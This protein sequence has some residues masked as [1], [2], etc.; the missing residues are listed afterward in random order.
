MDYGRNSPCLCG[1][2]KKYKKCCLDRVSIPP[3][4]SCNKCG[5]Q[6]PK[7][8]FEPL[9]VSEMKGIELAFSGICNSCKS[10][11]IAVSGEPDAASALMAM[12][13]D[14]VGQGE[15]G[16]ESFN[17]EGSNLHTALDGLIDSKN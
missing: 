6:A 7:S 17:S 5:G 10:M 4:I 11:T 16:V 13:Q 2:G 12:L 3:F 1:S 8:T 9:N 15:L 14:E